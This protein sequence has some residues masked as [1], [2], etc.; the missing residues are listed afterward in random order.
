MPTVNFTYLKKARVREDVYAKMAESWGGMIESFTIPSMYPI[1]EV[2]LPRGS[3]NFKEVQATLP[4]QH[5]FHAGIPPSE[6]EKV[7]KAAE[8]GEVYIPRKAKTICH[9]GGVGSGK[10]IAGCVDAVYHCRKY[11]GIKVVYAL[12]YDWYADSFLLPTLRDV[13][14][15][16]SPLLEKILYKERKYI[17]R[18]GS[19]IWIKAFD[20]ASKVKGFQMHRL[21]I[22][23]ASELGDG[24]NDKANS[25]YANLLMRM[26]A[27]GRQF[28]EARGVV[29]IQNPKGHNWV[30]HKFVK[31][32]NLEGGD[33]GRISLVPPDDMFPEGFEYGEYEKR[34]SNGE[35]AYVIRSESK[36]N[37]HNPGDYVG[38]ILADLQ[39]DPAVIARMVKGSFAPITSLVYGGYFQESTHIIDIYNVLDLWNLPTHYDDP[40]DAIP[41]NWPLT[42]GIDPAGSA[43]PWAIQFY[44]ETPAD[45]YGLTHYIHI[46]EIYTKSSSWD[47]M[48]ESILEW[49]EDGV[50]YKYEPELDPKGRQVMT[51][52]QTNYESLPWQNVRYF[53]DPF[54]SPQKLGPN[55]QSVQKEFTDRGIPVELPKHYNKESGIG[56]VSN[57]LRRDRRYAAPYRPDN[58]VEDEKAKDYG[59][60]EIGRSRLFY[61]GEWSGT[62][63]RIVP[64]GWYNIKE[65]EVYRR[66]QPKQRPPKES[67]E[68][69]SAAR[70]M[71]TV[72]VDDHAQTA[73]M[74]VFLGLDPPPPP[75]S[76]TRSRRYNPERESAPV[77][78]GHGRR[79]KGGID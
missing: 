76:K 74:F 5:L 13:L 68:G 70:D 21:Y 12:P 2:E 75:R 59:Q 8:Y 37:V 50:F 56:R 65:K 38:G 17:F 10:T 30:W 47:E 57:L 31:D 54:Y 66:E 29:I 34:L 67:E 53:A 69:L 64:Y 60:Y 39:D 26:R 63:K 79:R 28:D 36:S 77:L 22:E 14:P 1:R 7:E 46:G 25:I 19:Q 55:A 27:P 62:L 43:S 24:A 61:A 33:D 71:R 9:S 11:P 15:D 23:E 35:I 51:A 41:R 48:A 49:T 20:E 45:G 16:E 72:D 42:V 3:G 40:R 58:I 78:N 18:N 4:H 73:E 52:K 32:H 44:I 6:R